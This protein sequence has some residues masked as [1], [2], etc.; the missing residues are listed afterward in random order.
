MK[1]HWFPG[2]PLL[3]QR[4]GWFQIRQLADLV[5][6]LTDIANGWRRVDGGHEIVWPPW[7]ASPSLLV[8]WWHPRH[9]EF[10]ASLVGGWGRPQPW[11]GPFLIVF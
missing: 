6:R 3:R 10:T 9:W 4:S 7:S 8:M 11:I 5:R 2:W 1:I